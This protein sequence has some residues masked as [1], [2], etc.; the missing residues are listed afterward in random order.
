MILNILQ[1]HSPTAQKMK[2]P[3]QDFFIFCAVSPTKPHWP[4]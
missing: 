2:F 3:I 1:K 4:E